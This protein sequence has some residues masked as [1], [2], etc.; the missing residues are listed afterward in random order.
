MFLGVAGIIYYSWLLIVLFIAFILGY[1]GNK[2]ISIPGI[3]VGIIFLLLAVYTWSFSY[4]QKGGEK[5]LL[6]LPYRSKVKIN[7]MTLLSSWR[8]F[9]VYQ[10]KSDYQSYSVLMMSRKKNKQ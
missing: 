9:Q 6:K 3:V 1:E 8:N 7:Q 5:I 10:L 4:L 2:A